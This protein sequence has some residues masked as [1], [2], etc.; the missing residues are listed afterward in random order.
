MG[1]APETD[2]E[3]V[4]STFS[5]R[6]AMCLLFAF[7]LWSL[8]ITIRLSQFMVFSR[9]RFLAAMERES[10]R[11]G[12]IPPLRGRLLDRDGKPLAWS[13]RHFAL[14]WRVPKDVDVAER[15]WEDLRSEM[16]RPGLGAFDSVA[17]RCGEEVEL[18]RDLSA[19]EIEA[20]LPVLGAR[21]GLRLSS[22]F[23]RHRHPKAALRLGQ[24]TPLDGVQVGVSGYEKLHD[25]LLRGYPGVYRV[26]VDKRGDWISESWRKVREIHPGYDVYL[27]LRQED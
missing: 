7:C 13:T 16:G 5:R 2:V 15:A 20:L 27:P 1:E 11:Q 10:W 22:I 19:E 6:R 25:S 26:M 9:D 24:V 17:S 21:R 14:L 12:T 23:V 4:C 18:R 8:L 3:R